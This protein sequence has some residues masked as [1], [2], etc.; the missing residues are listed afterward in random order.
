[1]G[2]RS[3]SRSG[4]YRLGWELGRDRDALGRI[5][6]P[7]G[8]QGASPSSK[9]WDHRAV[10]PWAEFAPEDIR[11]EL[12]RVAGGG[13]CQISITH[14]PTGVRVDGGDDTPAEKARLLGLLAAAV[15]QERDAT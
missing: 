15:R 2:P 6:A 4:D 11:I 5:G 7:N 12:A 8:T 1:M 9:L 13:P 3:R 10:D 14:E